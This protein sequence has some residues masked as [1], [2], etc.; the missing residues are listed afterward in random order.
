MKM[1]HGQDCLQWLVHAW[2]A[3]AIVHEWL[4]LMTVKLNWYNHSTVTI[5]R[6]VHY[7]DIPDIIPYDNPTSTITLPSQPHLAPQP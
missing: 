7:P 2:L 1:A 5:T 4:T 3:L 6:L